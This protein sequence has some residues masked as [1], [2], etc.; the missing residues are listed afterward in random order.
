M[1]LPHLANKFTEGKSQT[2]AK[3]ADS[4]YFATQTYSA[5]HMIRPQIVGWALPV[6]AHVVHI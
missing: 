4:R 3:K 2:S 5:F 6:K 1:L